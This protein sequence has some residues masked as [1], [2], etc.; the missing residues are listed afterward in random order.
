MRAQNLSSPFSYTLLMRY[1]FFMWA[2]SHYVSFFLG[3]WYR[4]VRE[5]GAN[6][7][8]QL[9]ASVYSLEYMLVYTYQTTCL[10]PIRPQY[11]DF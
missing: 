7:S 3:L 6:I 9:T 8:E 4:V 1:E 2:M 10:K 11:E 5:M